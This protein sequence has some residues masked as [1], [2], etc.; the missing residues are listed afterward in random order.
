MRSAKSAIKLVQPAQANPLSDIF[1]DVDHGAKP[2]GHRVIVQMRGVRSQSRGGIIFVENAKQ[3]EQDVQQVARIV[4]LGPVA[5]CDRTTLKEWPEGAWVKPGD[6]VRVPRYG[7]DS[8]KVKTENGQEVEFRVFN[9]HQ[10]IAL[11]DT[12]DPATMTGYVA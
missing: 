5:F 7:G 4:A 2:L 10:I 11:L 3:T 1:P 6:Y 8:W 9:D 12:A